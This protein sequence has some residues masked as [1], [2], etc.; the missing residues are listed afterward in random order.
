MTPAWHSEAKLAPSLKSSYPGTILSDVFYHV[1]LQAALAE[2]LKEAAA[3][4]FL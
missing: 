2:D 3:A 1:I 4:H